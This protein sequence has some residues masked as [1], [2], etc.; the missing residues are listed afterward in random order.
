MSWSPVEN[1]YIQFLK[2][3]LGSRKKIKK[4]STAGRAR[5]REYVSEYIIQYSDDGELWSTLTD[6]NKEIQV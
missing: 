2:F 5:T 1:S 6:S 4:I 3:D